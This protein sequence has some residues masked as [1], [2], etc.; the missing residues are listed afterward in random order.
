MA[1]TQRPPFAFDFRVGNALSTVKQF[2]GSDGGDGDTG[3]L[4][5]ACRKTG[6]SNCCLSAAMS[7]LVS[8]IIPSGSELAAR[9]FFHRDTSEMLDWN[10]SGNF[11]SRLSRRISNLKPKINRLCQTALPRVTF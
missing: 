6:I 9:R 7:K 11:F 3:A 4:P 2:R 8:K 10:V 1:L 5:C